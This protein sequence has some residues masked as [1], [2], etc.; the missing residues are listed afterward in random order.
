MVL[1]EWFGEGTPSGVVIGVVGTGICLLASKR[2]L[3]PSVKDLAE[4]STKKKGEADLLPTIQNDPTVFVKNQEKIIRYTNPLTGKSTDKLEARSEPNKRLKVVFGVNNAFTTMD[5]VVA[6]TFVNWARKKLKAALHMD[7]EAS[8]E[9]SFRGL[10]HTILSTTRHHIEASKATTT[11]KLAETVQ[12]ITLRCSLRYLFGRKDADL[13]NAP[14]VIEVG[15]AINKLWQASKSADR[16]TWP[17]W[18]DQE[19]LHQ[20]LQALTGLDP[21]ETDQ[22][23]MNYILP[24]YETMWRAVFR[25]LLEIQ[26]RRAARAEKWKSLLSGFLN[27]PDGPVWKEPDDV[28]VLSTLDIV[29]EILRLYPPTR[30]VHRKF[31]DKPKQMMADIEGCH[32]GPLLAHDDSLRFFPERWVTMKL[33]AQDE[34]KNVKQFEETLGFFPFAFVCPAGNSTAGAFAFK[35]IALIIA[36]ICEQLD[37]L[38]GEWELKP[39]NSLP[40]L[41]QALKSGRDH[42][43]TL[44]YQKAEAQ[45]SEEGESAGK[46]L[47]LELGEEVHATTNDAEEDT[48]DSEDEEGLELFSSSM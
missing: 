12:F 18:E 21:T 5:A 7:S 8:Q 10:R 41:G 28:A 15:S 26:F 32:R 33:R 40:A 35:M 11:I 37:Q 13:N 30:R 39:E 25:G 24:A 31:D 36:S 17:R 6:N 34:E 43:L 44:V 2:L 16:T 23:P 9:G 46:E 22:N 47:G 45:L 19:K 27:T 3:R 48:R 1:K 42:Y 14:A 20:L 4:T 29:K 38:G